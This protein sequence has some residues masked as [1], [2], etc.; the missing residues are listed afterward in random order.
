MADNPAPTPPS[1]PQNPGLDA[2]MRQMR[3]QIQHLPGAPTPPPPRRPR[4]VDSRTWDY[5]MR[6]LVTYH[7]RTARNALHL[8]QPLS[9][10]RPFHESTARTRLIT[11]SNQA[12]KTSSVCYEIA[13]IVQGLHPL[14]PKNNGIMI[15]V[16]KNKDHVGTPMWSKLSR[17]GAFDIIPDEITGVWRAVRVNPLNPRE[18]DPVDVAR[19]PLWTESPPMLPMDSYHKPAWE[20]A[21]LRVPREVRMID[22]DWTMMFR[23]GGGAEIQ[24]IE[25]NLGW[26]DEEIERPQWYSETIARLLKRNGSFLWSATPQASTEQLLALHRL[27][28][29]GGSSI[30]EFQLLLEDNPYIPAAAKQE[31][32]DR[33]AVMGDDELAV[34]Y[35]GKYAILGR[36]VYGAWNMDNFGVDSFGVPA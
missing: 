35:Y 9:A 21:R 8:Y 12:G 29:A 10:A 31:M 28:Q 30:E 27:C 3:S 17:P 2:I 6:M 19:K 18:L 1:R 36:Q 34:R 15:C 24:G 4:A 25:A 5:F 22:T 33:W 16:G 7:Q 14:F 20:D 26:F 11:G 13:R 23:P 32:Y